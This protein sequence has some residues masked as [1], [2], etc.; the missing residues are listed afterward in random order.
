MYRSIYDFSLCLGVRSFSDKIVPSDVI[1]EMIKYA[2]LAP[3]AGNLQAR[4]FIII[5]NIEIK[6]RLS[7]A[8]LNQEF[9][10]EAPVNIVVG[11][12]LNRISSYGKRG[13]ELY[14]IQGYAAA[15]EHNSTFCRR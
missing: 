12:Q 8:A 10:I 3:S 14:C 11:A 4:E 13:R 15:I 1:H 2:N 5:D 9:I 6:K 7:N